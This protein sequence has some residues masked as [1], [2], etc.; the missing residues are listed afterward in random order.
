MVLLSTTSY[1]LVLN[2][3]YFFN[4]ETFNF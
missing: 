3:I 4:S 1:K 2:N